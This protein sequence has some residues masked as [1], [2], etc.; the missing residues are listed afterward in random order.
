M[1]EIEYG[2]LKEIPE[3]IKIF[4]SKLML[5]EP[6]NHLLELNEF[7]EVLVVKEEKDLINAFICLVFKF[8]PD[9][10]YGI[11]EEENGLI[12]KGYD[13]EKT[14]LYYLAMR[15]YTYGIDLTN[16]IS[17]VPPNLEEIFVRKD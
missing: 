9:I 8:D 6:L 1:D 2:N 13:L 5:D 17:R 3:K 16:F 4:Y 14:S 11:F 7:S 15:A 12:F 10:I